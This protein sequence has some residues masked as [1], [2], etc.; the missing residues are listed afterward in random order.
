MHAKHSYENDIPCLPH[1]D[2][3]DPHLT[4]WTFKVGPELMVAL[5]SGTHVKRE[6]ALD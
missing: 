3:R 5:L 6:V 4:H 1:S 2:N